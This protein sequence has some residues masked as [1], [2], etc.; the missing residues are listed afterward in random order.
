MRIET[1]AEFSDRYIATGRYETV[2]AFQA[3]LHHGSMFTQKIIEEMKSLRNVPNNVSTNYT[4][5]PTSLT[6]VPS[7]VGVAIVESNV[8]PKHARE[9]SS[10]KVYALS[11]PSTAQMYFDKM[12]GVAHDYAIPTLNYVRS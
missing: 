11:N 2:I 6:N 3:L 8:H 1:A 10:G 4:Y 9:N 12:K 7:I 5:I